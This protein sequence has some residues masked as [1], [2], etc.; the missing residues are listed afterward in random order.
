[1]KA[2]LFYY[3]ISSQGGIKY[4]FAVI[5]MMFTQKKAFKEEK[6]KKAP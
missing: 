2:L 6:V 4:K 5:A 3:Y 1:M